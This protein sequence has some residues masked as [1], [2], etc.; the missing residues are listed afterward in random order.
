VRTIQFKA[1][2]RGAAQATCLQQRAKQ[3]SKL[4]LRM[5]TYTVQLD[6]GSVA[7]HLHGAREAGGQGRFT[8]ALQGQQASCFQS[9]IAP[10]NALP[11]QLSRIQHVQLT[12]SKLCS[13]GFG[14]S[15]AANMIVHEGGPACRAANT[16]I[17]GNNPCNSY[18]PAKRVKDRFTKHQGHFWLSNATHTTVPAHGQPQSKPV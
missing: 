18:R 9:W 8:T 7:S 6:A 10:T 16:I 17:H 15:P 5:S 3:K 1:A 2:T 4:A 11:Q 14:S 12:L 13:A